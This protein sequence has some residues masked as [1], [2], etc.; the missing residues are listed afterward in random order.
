MKISNQ[1]TYWQCEFK[2]HAL[3]AFTFDELMRDLF[4]V[5]GIKNPF[6]LAFCEN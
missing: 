1:K 4:N 2:T 3:L 6:F 5:Y